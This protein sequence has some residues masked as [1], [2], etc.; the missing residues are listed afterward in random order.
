MKTVALVSGGMDSLPAMDK[1]YNILSCGSCRDLHDL[2]NKLPRYTLP[3]DLKKI[4]E[5]GIYFI[6]EK[7]EKSHDNDRIVYVGSHNVDGRL[8][9]RLKEHF[10]SFSKDGSIL[11]KNIGRAIL[12]KNFDSYQKIW[13]IDFSQAKNKNLYGM[14]RNKEYELGIENQVTGYINN[15]FTVAVLEV[16]DKEERLKLQKQIISLINNC[17]DCIPSEYWLGRFSPKPKI[18]N[19][20]LWMEKF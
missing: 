6:F 12:N 10:D 19:G 13:E 20:K 15:S 18:A 5:N 11:R 3:F 7:G 2:I 8:R 17:K 4:P 14:L 1:I 9:A 16:K